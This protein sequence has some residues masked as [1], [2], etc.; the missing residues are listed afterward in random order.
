MLVLLASKKLQ[1][2]TNT[3]RLLN[4]TNCCSSVHFIPHSR[5][6]SMMSELIFHMEI[7]CNFS[8]ILTTVE[9]CPLTF[10]VI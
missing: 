10:D 8:E 3:G 9:H 4:M 6:T 1:H 2:I 7:H 5:N